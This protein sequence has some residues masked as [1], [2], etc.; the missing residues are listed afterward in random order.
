[1]T[2]EW[3]TSISRAR[4]VHGHKFQY[5]PRARR[6]RV[7]ATIAKRSATKFFPLSLSLSLPRFKLLLDIFRSCHFSGYLPPGRTRRES[8]YA[9]VRRSFLFI[10]RIPAQCESVRSSCRP[11]ALVRPTLARFVA[12]SISRMPLV[13]TRDVQATVGLPGVISRLWTTVRRR[14]SSR[15]SG[16]SSVHPVWLPV[17]PGMYDAFARMSA[18]Q[19]EHVVF[20]YVGPPTFSTSVDSRGSLV[21]K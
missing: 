20:H 18:R 11:C 14:F 9:H 19:K 5:D 21:N 10:S 13:S 17:H 15:F 4:I 1:M 7:L 2:D 3:N 8:P 12:A 16:P 6:Q